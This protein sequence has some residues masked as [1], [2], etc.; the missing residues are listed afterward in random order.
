MILRVFEQGV[1]RVNVS[2]G[3]KLVFALGQFGLAL[4]AYGVGKLFLAFYVP[5]GSAVFRV[6]IPQGYIA[7]LFTV[8]GLIVAITRLVD[9]AA[10]PVSG[11]L[12]DR[13]TLPRGRRIPF[14]ARAALPLALFS[15]LV[16][17]PPF[18]NAL[19]ANALFAAAMVVA[20]YACLSLYAIPYLA[21]IAELGDR[22]RDRV[23]L[24]ALLASV[25]AL[26]TLLGNRVY[27]LADFFESLTGLLP[28]ASFRLTLAVFAC[29]GA[30][31]MLLPALVIDER[32]A[33]PERAVREGLFDS[34]GAVLKDRHFRSYVFS[35]FMFRTA[36]AFVIMGFSWH[37]TVLLGLP[38]RSA[39]LFILLVF[40][41]NLALYFPVCVA[42]RKLGK[43]KVLFIAFLLMTGALVSAAFAGLY[44]L[45]PFAQG[46]ILSLAVA[47]PYAVFSVLPIAVVA[48]LAVANERKTGHAR[49]GVYFGVHQFMAKSGELAAGI[50]MPL[51]LSMRDLSDTTRIPSSGSLRFTLAAAAAILFVGFLALFGYREKEVMSVLEGGAEIGR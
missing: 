39:D 26:A 2:M 46:T 50:V 40:F 7:S 41:S 14:M 47:V 33:H 30:I 35:D 11:W 29:L 32:K 19:G 28:L 3:K 16:F 1:L 36:A 37:V 38:R 22:P 23:F 13:S 49:A 43:R 27:T 45:S 6:Y 18:D 9:V 12:T 31:F 15:I 24:S 4:S 25:T 21:L 42:A 48:D 10:G 5:N 20:F 51:F 17:C 34:V 44:G 8:A